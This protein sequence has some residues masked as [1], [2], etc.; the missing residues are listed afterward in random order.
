MGQKILNCTFKFSEDYALPNSNSVVPHVVFGDQAF[1]L[2][3][4]ILVLRPFSQKSVRKD[5]GKT[6][7][8]YRLSRAR[9]VTENE[10]GLL[11]QIFSVL[12]TNKYKSKYM[13]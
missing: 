2:H 9:R 11:S 3:K 7:F 10:F 1:R 8:N 13:R 12:S 5:S 4:H 6:I